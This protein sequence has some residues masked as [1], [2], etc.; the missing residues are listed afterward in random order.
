MAN[1][2]QFGY[3]SGATLTYGV[4]QPD[5]TVRTAAGTSLPEIGSTGYYTA[6]DAS[7]AAQDAII[8]K[9]S[10]NVVGYGIYQPEATVANISDVQNGVA[11]EAKQDIIDT[12]VDTLIDNQFPDEVLVPASGTVTYKKKG[13]ATVLSTKDLKDPDGNAV[14]ST[15]DIIA[16]AIEQ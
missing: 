14:N 11:T 10:T 12:N 5:G 6:T 15:E 3:R 1:E 7:V 4:Y 9:E 13:T 2:I 16:E 8:V